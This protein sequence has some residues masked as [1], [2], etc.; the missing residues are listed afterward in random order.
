MFPGFVD[1]CVQ[2]IPAPQGGAKAKIEHTYTGGLESD[3]GETMAECDPDVSASNIK[4]FHHQGAD[5]P[6]QTQTENGLQNLLFKCEIFW[7]ISEYLILM[8]QV[9]TIRAILL[10]DK[11]IS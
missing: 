10:L 9:W 11:N 4:H 8:I 2:H 3:L 6:V 5:S 1:M 7:L